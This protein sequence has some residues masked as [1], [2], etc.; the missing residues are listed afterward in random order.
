MRSPRV[1]SPTMYLLPLSRPFLRDPGDGGGGGSGDAAAKSVAEKAAAEVALAARIA[2][3]EK[4]AMDAEAALAAAAK[5]KAD[6]EAAEAA[7]RGEFEKL[8]T[9]YK[10]EL[11][12]KVARLAELEA[13]E[14]ARL[15]RV[16]AANAKIIEAIPADRRTLVPAQLTGDAL[17]EYLDTNRALLLGDKMPAGTAPRGTAA[18]TVKLTDDDRAKMARLGIADEATYIDVMTKAGRKVGTTAEA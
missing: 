2:A 17:A 10:S 14:A 12:A 6:D 5:A 9:G 11:D 3:I 13:A 18:S 7:K 16:T 1:L 15:V 4:R 8:A